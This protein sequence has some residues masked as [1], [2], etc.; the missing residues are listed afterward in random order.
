[1]AILHHE[2][3]AVTMRLL[4][5]AGA[6]QDP[7]EA[8]GGRA[9][10]APARSGHDH[11]HGAADCRAD[12]LHRWRAGTGSGTDLTFVNAVVMKDSFAFGMDLVGDVARNPAFAPEEIERQ[13]E[14][15]ISSLQVSDEDPTTSPRCCSTASC[16]A[17]IRT[18]CQ[19]AARP[20]R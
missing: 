8:R 20:R 7:Q 15:A 11:A 4:T 16:M 6:A 13:R 14:R 2:Q 3:P 1:M 5:R 12:R 18:V 17:S 19:A 10:G 9:R